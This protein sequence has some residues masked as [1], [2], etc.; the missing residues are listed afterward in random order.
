M[1]TNNDQQT[2]RILELETTLGEV[3]ACLRVNM[4]MGRLTTENDKQFEG[5]INHWS[6]T[7]QGMNVVHY[8]GCDSTKP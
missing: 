1:T 8:N 7:L 2:Y 5:F 3:L 6:D 4:S